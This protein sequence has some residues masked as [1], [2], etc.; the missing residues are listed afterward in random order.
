MTTKGRPQRV[1]EVIRQK[2]AGLLAKGLKDPRIGF[3][4]VMEVRMSADLQYA[5]V[6][7]STLGSEAERKGSLI[8]LRS[9]AGWIRR[10]VGKELKIRVTPEI[11]FFLDD[12][13][14]Q[15]YHLEEVFE[16]I[17][18]EQQA[19]PMIKIGLEGVL[20]ELRNHDSF[21]V[22][23]HVSPDGDAIGSML[24]LAHFLR[25]LGKT[26]VACVMHDRVPSIYSDLPGAQYVMLRPENPPEFDAAIMIDIS[27]RERLG[28]V[29]ALI[30][31]E[32]RLIV[33][34]HHLSEGP[35]GSVGCIDPSFAAAG[36]MVAE[37][38]ALAGVDMTP[39]AAHC[40]Y[41]ALIT[42][43]GGFRFSNTQPRSLRLAA[44]LVE[45]GLDIAKISSRVFDTMPL[46]KFE[47]LRRVL[48]RMEIMSDGRL[49]HTYVTAQDMAETGAQ[50]EHLDSL[51]NYARNIEG[52]CIGALF[53]GP[54]PE[55][56]KVSLR[57]DSRFNS[58][59]FLEAFGG[60][61]HA[62]AAGATIDRSLH[63]VRAEIV[64][65]LKEACDAMDG[66]SPA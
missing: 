44:E 14:D 57:S 17:H 37:L 15:V 56:T 58:A 18:R 61:G 5:N 6:Y 11:R 9:A 49:A 1:G 26:A 24:G 52:V 27:G 43:T 30:T 36:E 50:K 38:Y 4:S 28:S 10:E 35:G 63:E 33:I 59:A 42:D 66:D 51:V 65:Q 45:R 47:L 32:K 54:E 25:A 2:I 20:E 31:P 53:F 29:D 7:V 13:L 46:P 21:L 55:K 64:T 48:D 22:T 16:E 62:A 60:G 19:A 8:G 39:A 12:T 40:L 34:D 23:T 3:V 41:A